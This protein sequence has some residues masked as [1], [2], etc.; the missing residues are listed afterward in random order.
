MFYSPRLFIRDWWI[1]IP[2]L[3]S[4]GALIFIFFYTLTNVHPGNE[5]IFLHYNVIFGVDLA[6]EWWK[7]YYLSAASLLFFLL[8]FGMAW[9]RYRSDRLVARLL[10]SVTGIW[11]I[12]LVVATVLIVGLNI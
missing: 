6:G 2:F 9:W 4:L 7:I 3:I 10:A 12:F 5:Q 11:E 1:G 8:N